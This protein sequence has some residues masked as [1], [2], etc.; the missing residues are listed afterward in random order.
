MN[1][2]GKKA[3]QIGTGASRIQVI[4]EI[5]PKVGQLT[6]YQRTP[7]YLSA[8]ESENAGREGGREKQGWGKI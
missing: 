6:I 2:K 7:N 4:Q 3:A 5:G 8:H 1:T